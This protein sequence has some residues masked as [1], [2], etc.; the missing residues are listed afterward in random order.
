MTSTGKRRG[1][2]RLDSCC[3]GDPARWCGGAA[4][5]S[6]QRKSGVRVKKQRHARAAARP[7]HGNGANELVLAQ[8]D[9][10]ARYRIQLTNGDQPRYLYVHGDR[11]IAHRAFFSLFRYEMLQ[12]V[13]SN[14]EASLAQHALGDHSGQRWL[15]HQAFY[16]EG[17]SNNNWTF[18]GKI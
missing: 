12:S 11:V 7:A 13:T 8:S 10:G 17:G 5:R 2:G 18:N 4:A 14:S 1:G 3:E 6:S 16:P 15:Q 9:S